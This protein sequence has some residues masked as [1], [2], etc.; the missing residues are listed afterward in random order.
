MLCVC[1]I[2]SE[3]CCCFEYKK[4]GGALGVEP[5]L[6]LHVMGCC[7]CC[8][9]CW[10]GGW[11]ECDWWSTFLDIAYVAAAPKPI[12]FYFD[13]YEKK[14]REKTKWLLNPP[15]TTHTSSLVG[16]KNTFSGKKVILKFW[17]KLDLPSRGCGTRTRSFSSEPRCKIYNFL[18]IRW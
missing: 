3:K 8:C 1:D 6:L 14:K 18:Q 16:A 10:K 15:K 2:N 13:F 5:F 7:C 12:F 9:C 17:I 11:V 4:E